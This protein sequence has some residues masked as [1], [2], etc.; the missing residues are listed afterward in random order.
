MCLFKKLLTHSQ[1]TVEEPAEGLYSGREARRGLCTFC[2]FLKFYY[3]CLVR[4]IND[5][6]A[7]LLSLSITRVPYNKK[8]SNRRETARQLCISFYRLANRSSNSLNT[9]DV[10]Q[11]RLRVSHNRHYQLRKRPTCRPTHGL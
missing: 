2:C 6:T 9:A 4:N 7:T 10:V 11:F 8:L 3:C 5:R 1:W